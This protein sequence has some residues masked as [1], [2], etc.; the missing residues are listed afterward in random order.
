MYTG[1]VLRVERPGLRDTGGSS[2]CIGASRP[3]K[4]SGSTAL[5]LPFLFLRCAA[6]SVLSS[7]CMAW[8]CGDCAR[9]AGRR[10][11]LLALLSDILDK[12]AWRLNDGNGGG[13]R[14]LVYTDRTCVL[15]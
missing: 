11:L 1:F 7:S 14:P 8:S 10:L 9:G 2:S 3:A 15:G 4:S 6:D 12:S 5:C 13:A